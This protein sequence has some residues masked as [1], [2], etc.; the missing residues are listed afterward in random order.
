MTGSVEY[1]KKMIQDAIEILHPDTTARKLAE[2]EYYGGF[3]G[4]SDAIEAVN[5][6]CRIACSIMQEYLKK[7][8]VPAGKW[9]FRMGHFE[10]SGIP[11]EEAICSHCNQVTYVNTAVASSHFEQKFIEQHEFCPRCG[12]R[13][14]GAQ[15]KCQM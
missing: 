1:P 7:S 11:R 12:V 14:E 15:S 6:A 9:S 8:N 4:K 5:N 13:M 2:I 10:T 3:R